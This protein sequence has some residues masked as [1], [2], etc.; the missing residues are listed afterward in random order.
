MFEALW[1]GDG[2]AD[3]DLGALSLIG[4][5][6]ILFRLWDRFNELDDVFGDEVCGKL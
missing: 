5:C 3:R 4:D 6:A 2:A 1:A